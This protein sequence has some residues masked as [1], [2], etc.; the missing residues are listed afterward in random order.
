MAAAGHEQGVQGLHERL[1]HV[2]GKVGDMVR[3]I[4]EVEK[5]LDI[6]STNDTVD[7]RIADVADDANEKIAAVNEKIDEKAAGL[8]AAMEV[9]FSMTLSDIKEIRSEAGIVKARVDL[10]ERRTDGGRIKESFDRL[11]GRVSQLER[12]A[13]LAG[14]KADTNMPSQASDMPPDEHTPVCK[15]ERTPVFKDEHTP[16]YKSAFDRGFRQGYRYGQ[17]CL[18][19]ERVNCGFQFINIDWAEIHQKRHEM[20]GEYPSAARDVGHAAGF[21]YGHLQ[22]QLVAAGIIERPEAL[23]EPEADPYRGLN[24]YFSVMG[25]G[26]QVER[27]RSRSPRR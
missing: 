22:A 8:D 25:R 4:E 16:I 23:T 24:A 5:C 10:L 15:D 17:N 2:E 20:F 9:T 13:T 26:L 27:P 11:C 21:Q 14:T 19:D 6:A 7:E 18:K 1:C 3:Q 12:V